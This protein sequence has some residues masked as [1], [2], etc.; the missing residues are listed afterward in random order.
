MK[1]ATATAALVAG[2][3]ILAAPLQA[4]TL[5]WS[6]QGDIATMDPYAHTESFTSNMHHYVYDPLVRRNRKLEIEPALATSWS[7]VA[8]DRWRFSHPE[9]GEAE[10]EVQGS[11]RFDSGLTVNSSESLRVAALA[12]MGLAILPTYAIGADLRAGLLQA[13]LP[14]WQPVGGPADA[15]ALYAVY[16]PHRQ[17]S[18]KVRALIDFMLEK[19]GEVP[20]WDRDPG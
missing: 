3:T 15:N 18:P 2:L 1:R 4:N 9:L 20:P 7:I 12:G 17:P 8:P 19:L 14:D 13:L 10:V 16:L 5:R 6:S 11:L